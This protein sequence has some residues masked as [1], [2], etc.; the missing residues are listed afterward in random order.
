MDKSVALEWADTSGEEVNKHVPVFI[1]R[2]DNF[3][4]LFKVSLV[5]EA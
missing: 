5:E 3:L 4:N 1:N 2:I